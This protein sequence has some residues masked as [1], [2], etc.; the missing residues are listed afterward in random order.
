[1]V[2]QRPGTSPGV[3]GSHPASFHSP[4]YPWP[5]KDCLVAVIYTR[6]TFQ[7]AGGF[8]LMSLPY[9]G[10]CEPNSHSGHPDVLLDGCQQSVSGL[11]VMNFPVGL[12]SALNVE[13][14]DDSWG[15]PGPQTPVGMAHFHTLS[16]VRGMARSAPLLWGPSPWAPGSLL[17]LRLIPGKASP[18]TAA[19][20]LSVFT[21]EP[22]SH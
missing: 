10:T 7:G 13:E 21:R 1:M 19:S 20:H 17:S 3:S 22:S 6:G 11:W 18:P 2:L 5:L 15:S 14:K 8:T 12:H 16:T 9:M 4:H